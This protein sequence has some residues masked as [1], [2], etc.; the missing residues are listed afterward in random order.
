MQ[1]LVDIC[2]S[3]DHRQTILATVNNEPTTN[4]TVRNPPVLRSI[5]KPGKA[6]VLRAARCVKWGGTCSWAWFSRTC[7]TSR[8]SLPRSTWA[9]RRVGA[10]A[11][12]FGNAWSPRGP[13][14]GSCWA[15]VGVPVVY[16]DTRGLSGLDA[17]VL[18]PYFIV[19]QTL[20]RT[21]AGGSGDL[22]RSLKA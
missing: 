21:V 12:L 8:L 7:V 5:A 19:L 3:S 18:A 20:V 9:A 11:V 6:C 22:V 16:D 10:D 13:P 4:G 15:G 14:R 2:R 17:T 1:R